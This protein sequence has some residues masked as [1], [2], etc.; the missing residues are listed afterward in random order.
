[1]TYPA[2]GRGCAFILPQL[3]DRCRRSGR[4]EGRATGF[5]S[6]RNM[7]GL[8]CQPFGHRR[9]SGHD[10]ELSASDPVI[11]A[12][13]V[14]SRPRTQTMARTLLLRGS[15]VSSTLP[16]ASRSGGRYIPKRPR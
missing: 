8:G 12:Q 6:N 9:S 3:A 4:Q 14:T 15:W 7:N 10:D 11:A 13:T 5:V 16:R 1:M 2:P